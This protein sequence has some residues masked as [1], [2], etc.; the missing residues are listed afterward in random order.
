MQVRPYDKKAFLPEGFILFHFLKIH[1]QLVDGNAFENDLVHKL[2]IAKTV[3]P[4][5]QR[6]RH[7]PRNLM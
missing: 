1:D 6:L 2:A 3:L 7:N 4:T 5:K